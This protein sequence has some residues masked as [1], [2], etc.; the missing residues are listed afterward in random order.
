M[1]MNFINTS[2]VFAQRNC[3]KPT[4]ELAVLGVGVGV[5]HENQSMWMTSGLSSI[6]HLVSR[7]LAVISWNTNVPCQKKKSSIAG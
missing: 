2:V 4:H 7:D 5:A 6:T 1:W 3:N